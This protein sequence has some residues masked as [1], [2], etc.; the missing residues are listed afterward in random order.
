MKVQAIYVSPVKSLELNR[1]DEAE[2]TKRGIRGDRAFFLLDERGNVL[3]QREYPPIVRVAAAYD[4]SKERLR[5]VFPDLTVESEIA[6]GEELS[7]AF[8]P[9][10]YH[11]RRVTGPFED[12]LSSFAGQPVRLAKVNEDA[13]LAFDGYPLSLC[14]DASVA[15]VRD[16]A[17]HD[18]LDERR[19]RQNIY[20]GGAAEPHEEDTWI[21]RE[22]AVGDVTLRVKMRDP[23]CVITTRDPDTGEQDVNTLKVIASY[24]TDQPKEVNF[25]VYCTVAR[26][27]IMRVGDE[28]RVMGEFA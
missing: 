4:A 27:G 19:F 23:R 21:G 12:A 20:I 2:I 25:G 9:L 14:S 10:T 28:V 17:A 22:V 11:G 26:P 16:A 5:L 13:Y 8:S 18:A 24:R 6:L 15:R 3:T 7:G 1:V